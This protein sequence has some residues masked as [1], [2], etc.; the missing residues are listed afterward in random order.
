MADNDKSHQHATEGLYIGARMKELAAL[1][2]LNQ[3]KFALRVGIDPRHFNAFWTDKRPASFETIVKVA[4]A[5]GHS[6]AWVCGEVDGRP[7]LG[8]VDHQGRITMPADTLSP[9]ILY[10]AEASAHF[11]VGARLFVDP[12]ERFVPG[13]WL[14]VRT[15]ND[16]VP[17]LGWSSSG[18]VETL[19]R[20]DGELVV[21]N[22]DRHAVIGVVAGM[23]VVPPP[24]LT[25][26][27]SATR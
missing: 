14:V 23:L 5:T 21:Y 25:A 7:Q 4:R 15:V 18:Q 16:H 6:I 17:W 2:G 27:K 19:E 3:R 12:A 26:G 9:G 20:C 10:F 11:A 22:P 13:Q 24:P 1:S 8:T